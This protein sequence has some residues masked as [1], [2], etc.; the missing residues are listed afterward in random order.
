MTEQA[1][2]TERNSVNSIEI[3]DRRWMKLCGVQRVE[4]FDKEQVNL[5][6]TAGR[7]V[8]R[9]RD[10]HIAQLLPEHEELELVGEIDSLSFEEEPGA[11]RRSLLS[12][13]TK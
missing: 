3:K 6:T 13:L 4:D 8:V 2:R 11:R 12:R 1:E 9:G 5:A 10:L 7:L